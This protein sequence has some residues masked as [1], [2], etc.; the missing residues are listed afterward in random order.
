M[1]IVTNTQKPLKIKGFWDFFMWFGR[2]LTANYHKK[3]IGIASIILF[4]MVKILK[5]FEINGLRGGCIFRYM[6]L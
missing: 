6:K 5:W 4:S 3:H 1:G 2:T